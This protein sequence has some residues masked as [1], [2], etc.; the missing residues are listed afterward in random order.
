[1]PP[2]IQDSEDEDE[3]LFEDEPSQ[4]STFSQLA[5]HATS[6]LKDFPDVVPQLDG[7]ADKPP[8][9][10]SSSDLRRQV[11]DA[12]RGLLATNSD[13]PSKHAAGMPSS[14][15]PALQRNKRRNTTVVGSDS[16]VSPVKSLKRVKTYAQT[17]SILGDDDDRPHAPSGLPAG[18]IA[19]DFM[20]HEPNVM[21]RDT[22]TTNAFNDSTQ[23]ELV[24]QARGGNNVQTANEAPLPKASNSDKSSSFPWTASAEP[25][26]T[27]GSPVKA[28]EQIIQRED[29]TT[30][31]QVPNLVRR[32]TIE[33]LSPVA[34][35]PAFFQKPE[36]DRPGTQEAAPPAAKARSPPKSSPVVI[37]DRR[38]AVSE[39]RDEENSG[40][41]KAKRGRKRKSQE[42]VHEQTQSD[43]RLDSDD[44]MLKEMGLP[45]DQYK[46]RPSRRRATQVEEPLDMSLTVERA[47]RKQQRRKTDNATAEAATSSQSHAQNGSR[48]GLYAC[49]LGC[50][51]RMTEEEVFPH[52]DLCPTKQKAT[53]PSK[54]KAT[55]ENDSVHVVSPQKMLEKGRKSAIKPV[56]VEER[57]KASSRASSIDASPSS[58]TLGQLSSEKKTDVGL[59]L[60]PTMPASAS[61]RARR[62]KTTIFEDHVDFGGSQ[63]SPNLSQ[64]QAKRKAAL[65]EVTNGSTQKSRRKIVQDDEDDEDEL[66]KEEAEVIEP[67]QK[68]AR[69]RPAKASTQKP[70]KSS[71]RVLKD[72]DAED[73]EEEIE[74]KPP[75]KPKARGRSKTVL[76]DSDS[77]D[78]D[79]LEAEEPPV[80]KGRGRPPKTKSKEKVLQNSDSENDDLE[81]EEPVAK[82]GRGR[83]PKAKSKEKV[84]EDS[85]AVDEDPNAEEDDVELDE[86]PKKKRPGRPPKAKA[87]SG[88]PVDN[89]PAKENSEID[90]PSS[91]LSALNKGDSSPTKA[92]LSRKDSNQQPKAKDMQSPRST[93]PQRPDAK[94]APVTHSPIKSITKAGSNG[95]FPTYRVGLS[96][97]RKIPSLLKIVGKP[98]PD[99]RR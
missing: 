40:A 90:I 15:S 64:Q 35:R 83:P 88:K 22:G 14:T 31:Q 30:A 67:P 54:D 26:Q 43:D 66:A 42:A 62:S 4:R 20:N 55:E 29:N 23:E 25:T 13:Q 45:E 76:Q 10:T 89:A 47:V 87:D 32:P 60:P 9:G 77:D 24:E 95:S 79:E 27:E 6:I 99:T 71:E 85:D 68:R 19:D 49:P 8:R 34:K 2:A 48:D 51:S 94:P 12:E 1:M 70:A 37:I 46:P 50:S 72:S 53:Q 28:D 73:D 84:L 80:K 52:L 44:R 3:I 61:K 98:R 92:A 78:D 75:A 93:P 17:R 82:K 59:M 36:D 39:L 18:T 41:Q 33:P 16:G 65:L 96:K 63:R 91:D 58:K 74:L 38:D 86:S 7:A 69:G 11:A 81:A 21:F 57:P 5:D 97:T 56:T